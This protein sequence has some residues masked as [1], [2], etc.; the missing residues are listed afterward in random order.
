[1]PFLAHAPEMEGLAGEKR[2]GVVHR[3]DKDTSGLILFAKNDA[4]HR[5]LQEQFSPPPGAEVLHC[6]GGWSPANPLWQSR[7]GNWAR[8]PAA[9]QNGS[10]ARPAGPPGSERVPHP[11]K[12]HTAYPAGCAAIT[13]RTHQIRL[14][15]AFINC[16]IAG[17]RVYGRRRASIN[18]ER[19]FLHARR[20]DI[21]LPGEKLPG[22]FEAPMPDELEQILENL[23]KQ[24]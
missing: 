14:H 2:P 12:F 6:P 21:R 23:R 17:D 16:P 19:H 20:L 5:W 3:L 9:S 10:R 7:G 13:G 11:G 15:M 22:T 24:S 4:T 8:S 1:M 18:L